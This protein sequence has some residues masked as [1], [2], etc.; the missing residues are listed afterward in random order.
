MDLANEVGV[1]TRHL[2]FVETGRSRPSPELVLALAHHLEVPLREQNTMLL[3]AGYAPRYSQASLDEPAMDHVRTSI[4]R[5]LAAHDPY[6][7]VAV[8]R[9]WNVVLA[10]GSALRVLG[11]VD[12][13][14][15]GP[16]ANVYRLSLHPGGL[17]GFTT[18]FEEWA[19]HLLRQLERS[20]LIT[21]D[22]RLADLLVE[23]GAYPT[24]Q[25]LELRVPAPGDAEPTVLIPM[26]LRTPLGEV[27]MF[28]TIT[29]FGT[30]LD[31]TVEELAI[32]LFF[33]VDDQSDH[34]LR[35][36]SAAAP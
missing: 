36:L 33:P 24:V 1:S 23:V 31:V 29:T 27:S 4:E 7:G 21:G 13:A 11:G 15:L 35:D 19:P 3:A 17:A 5:L 34:L 25:G 9:Q 20:A 6:P 14:L 30:P 32:E 8:D 22:A 18:N 26:R 2:S 12:P 28:T 10:N 16:P